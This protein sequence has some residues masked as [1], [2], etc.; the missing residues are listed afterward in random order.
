MFGRWGWEFE[1]FVKE[2]RF[3]FLDFGKLLESFCRG[4]CLLF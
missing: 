1:S 3:Y 2:V 4:V